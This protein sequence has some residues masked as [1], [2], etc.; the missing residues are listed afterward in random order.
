MRRITVEERRARLA[1]RH[2][3]GPKQQAGDAADVAAAVVALHATDPASVFLSARARM[4]RPTTAQV[5]AALYDDRTLVRMLGMRRTMFVVPTHMVSVVDAACTR[6]IAAKERT[7]LVALLEQQGIAKDGAR[8]LGKVEDATIAALVRR[9]A[10]LASEL[11]DDVPEL[12]RTVQFGAGSKWETLQPVST[13]VVFLLAAQG[14][15]IRGRPRGSWVSSQYRWYPTDVW[16]PDGIEHLA[17]DGA[18]VDLA[19]RWLAAFGPGTAVDLQ[20]WTGWTLG[21]ARKALAGAAAVEVDLDGST[22]YVLEDDVAPV[23]SPGPWVALLPGLDPTAMGWKD[24]HWYLG[25]HGSALVDRSGN[26]G[27][28]VW[29]DGRVVGGWA[30]RKDSGVV[31]RLLED[32]GAEATAAVAEAAGQLDGWLG[33]VAVTTRFPSPLERELKA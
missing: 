10:A 26:I 5:E 11:S 3:L 22:G 25:S 16:L 7:R 19:R 13:R 28:T 23:R 18:R 1:R 14:R 15:M 31:Y 29:C 8:W 12:R 30:C 33:G 6:A 2:R 21:E 27:P 32:V 17:V 9:G 4:K 20:W 24:R